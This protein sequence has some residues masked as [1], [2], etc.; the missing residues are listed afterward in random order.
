MES[1]LLAK[2][3]LK[4]FVHS[5]SLGVIEFNSCNFNLRLDSKSA[6]LVILAY[7]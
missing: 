2:T 7:S 5:V 1:L 3:L 6:S 4:K